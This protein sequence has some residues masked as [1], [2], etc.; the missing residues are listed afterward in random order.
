MSEFNS[1]RTRW[2]AKPAV[3]TLHGK[4]RFLPPTALN[5]SCISVGMSSSFAGVIPLLE[6]WSMGPCRGL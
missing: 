1:K 5:L 6:W 2:V 4:H 3:P